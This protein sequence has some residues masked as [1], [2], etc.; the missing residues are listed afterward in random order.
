MSSASWRTSYISRSNWVRQQRLRPVRQGL[1]GARV[2]FDMNSIGAPAAMAASAIAGIKS[3]RPVAWLG[4]TIMGK[5]LCP[6]ML[7]TI[8]R[9]RVLRVESSKVLIP[10]SHR[11]ACRFPS[12]RMVLG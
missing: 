9:S 6:W 8:D 3:G 4:S 7:G 11:T 5:W 1:L 2:D 10:R 12:D